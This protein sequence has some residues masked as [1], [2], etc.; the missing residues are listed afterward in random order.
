MK[1]K[2]YKYNALLLMLVVL[3]LAMLPVS[4]QK[5]S[6]SF[7]EL[8]TLTDTGSLEVENRYG[9]IDI[10]NW[11]KNEISVEVEVT[12]AH[13]ER[14][15]AEK[16]LSYINIEFSRQGNDVR[17][18]TIIDQRVREQWLRWFSSGRDETRI[19][20][21]YTIYVPAET[22]LRIANR[23]GNIFIN[24]ALGHTFIDLRYGNLQANSIIRDN[25]RPLSEINL[26]Y[27]TKA[28]IS[29]A[30]W[31]QVNLRY[32]DLSVTRCRALVVTSSYSKIRVD[33]ASSI[34][35]ESRYG[36]FSLGNI[37]NFVAESA[38]TNYTINQIGSTLD[39]QSRYGN[40]RI[41][42]MP[43]GF[44]KLRFDSSYGNLRAGIDSDASYKISASGSYGSVNVP[45]GNR[46]NRTTRGSS[47]N[48]SGIV[49]EAESPEAVVEIS[50]RYGNVDLR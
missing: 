25:T 46:I 8:F 16:Q 24:E 32:S 27:S 39:V 41:G 47:F 15:V 33:Q 23:Y 37:N 4:G 7:S 19:T 20:V 43:A 40:V 30:D 21:N 13:P 35:T 45:S 14:D 28:T 26:A 11:E 9:N 34:V 48:I 18:V 42:N 2:R 17:A 10:M 29:E 1:A 6:K 36:E 49:G 5:A 50:T 31:L 22:G 3:P 12:V 44:S 38:Y